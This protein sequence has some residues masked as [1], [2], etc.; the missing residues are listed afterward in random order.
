MLA[1]LALTP[2]GRNASAPNASAPAAARP[3]AIDAT[4][5][6]TR[7]DARFA[8]SSPERRVLAVLDAGPQLADDLVRATRVSPRDLG[9]ALSMLSIAGLV[10]VDAGGLV[11]R[12]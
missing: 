12:R 5:P 1:L 10:D 6:R 7:S 9:V 3:S 8:E 4:D 2:R 11:S